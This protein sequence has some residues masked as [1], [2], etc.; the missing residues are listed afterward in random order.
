M[1]GLFTEMLAYS[2]R[3]DQVLAVLGDLFLECLHLL[4]GISLACVVTVPIW[5]LVFGWWWCYYR[6]QPLRPGQSTTLCVTFKADCPN[7]SELRLRDTPG[8]QKPFVDQKERR[9]L[10]SLVAEAGQDFTVADHSFRLQVQSPQARSTWVSDTVSQSWS[11]RLLQHLDPNR[12]P[13]LPHGSPIESLELRYPE[14]HYTWLNWQLAWWWA[15][16]TVVV[17]SSL[18]LAPSLLHREE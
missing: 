17:I 15:P 8:Q 6:L 5:A 4:R 10:Y 16:L 18:A 12:H 13:V 3:P 11:S 7:W 14:R 9:I 1:L 2:E